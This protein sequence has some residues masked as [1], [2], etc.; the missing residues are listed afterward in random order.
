MVVNC[1]VNATAAGCVNSTAS[2][3]SSGGIAGIAV[4]AVV[5]V[6]IIILALLCCCCG[7]TKK[8]F[9]GSGNTVIYPNPIREEPTVVPMDQ[10]QQFK[11]NPP[12]A[13]PPVVRPAADGGQNPVVTV[14]RPKPP[15]PA[16][17]PD[18]SPVNEPSAPP[19]P[20]AKDDVV[21]NLA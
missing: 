4:G 3:L 12:P 21:E 9:G 14:N 17:Q 2:A 18:P 5:F 6:V 16:S 11:P 20:P 13:P 15:P 8:C 1:T 7:W 19:Q 10:G